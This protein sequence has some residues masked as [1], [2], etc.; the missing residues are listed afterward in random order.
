MSAACPHILQTVFA[1]APEQLRY[2][3]GMSAYPANSFCC[4]TCAI[5]TC[6]RHVLISSKQFFRRHILIAQ[7]RLQKLFAGY[8]DMPP[9]YLNCAGAAAKTVC[10]I[11]GNAAHRLRVLR[12]LHQQLVHRSRLQQ[13]TQG[14]KTAHDSTEN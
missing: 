3:G 8:A 4:R 10:G 5:K 11:C 1:A 9:T 7:V 2:V 6:W 14:R 13:L 12:Q